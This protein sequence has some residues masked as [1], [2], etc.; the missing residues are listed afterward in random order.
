MLWLREV[1]VP[2]VVRFAPTS[3][4]SVVVHTGASSLVTKVSGIASTGGAILF[5]GAAALALGMISYALFSGTMI[6]ETKHP[7]WGGIAAFFAIGTLAAAGDRL[8]STRS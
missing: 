5:Y 1:Y 2:P 4:T 3:S 7:V 6:V 8:S